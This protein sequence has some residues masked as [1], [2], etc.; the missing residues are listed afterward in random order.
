MDGDHNAPIPTAARI[1]TMVIS[2]VTISVL[3]G[4]YN[5]AKPGEHSQFQLVIICIYIDSFLFV[6]VT[7]VVSKSWSLNQSPVVCQ[8]AVLLCLA[9]YMTTKILIYFFLVE[10]AYVVRGSRGPRLKNKLW[11]CNFFGVILPYMAVIVLSFVFRIGYINRRGTCYIG[12]KRVALLPLISFEVLINLYL[13]SLFLHPLRQLYSYSHGTNARLRTIAIRTF[14]GSCTTLASSVTNLTVLAILGA[15]PG[16]V[17]LMLCNLDILVCVLVLHWATA[18]D[19]EA[20]SAAP[21]PPSPHP[22]RDNMIRLPAKIYE[23]SF[24]GVALPPTVITEI[25]ADSEGP[26]QEAPEHTIA[27]DT[28]HVQ[29]VEADL[30]VAGG[31]QDSV[32]DVTLKHG[33]RPGKFSSKDWIMGG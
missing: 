6:F 30:D 3:R 16:W 17:C 23:P 29:E 31:K 7:A 20:P 12:I 14:A 28:H 15:E 21:N 24:S 32:L 25:A 19:R 13:T 33:V 2:M 9:F 27:V 1:V 10:K 18:V 11:L 5:T 22:V 4:E 8:T 26:R